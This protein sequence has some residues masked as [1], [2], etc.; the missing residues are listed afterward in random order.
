MRRP[1]SADAARL[2]VVF[3]LAAGLALVELLFGILQHY[4]Q[5]AP[6]AEALDVLAVRPWLLVPLALAAARLS[7]PWR[8]GGY[9]AF[10]LIAGLTESLYVVRMGNPDPWPEMVRGWTAAILLLA[11]VDLALHL[12][13]RTRT[14]WAPIALGAAILLLFAFPPA[15]APYRAIV[16]GGAADRPAQTQPDLL[17]MTALPIVWGEGGAF[18][19]RSQPAL[20]YRALQEEFAIRPIDS[21]DARTL[22]GAG[23]LLLA[24]PRWLAPAELVAVDD[25]V[26]AG[27]RILILTDPQLIWPTGLPLGDIRRPPPVG[28]LK[29]LLDHWGVALD[30]PQAGEVVVVDSGRRLV[31][32]RP[33]RFAATGES[34]RVLGSWRAECRLGA[35]RA[36]LIADADLLRDDLWAA[37]GADGGAMHR[38]L[39]DNPLAVADLLDRLSGID[40]GRVRAPVHWANPTMSP[41]RALILAILPLLAVL[42]VALAASGLLHRGRSA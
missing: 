41:R 37:A 18:D 15:L 24:Q 21:L 39:A 20:A 10:L 16:L 40:R 23:L 17:L 8:I 42:A 28:L 1:T 38:R 19:P 13:R 36:T 5:A 25:W 22:R 31:L 6:R 32:D 14:G 2:C 33:G 7:L 11:A 12:A 4:P 26:R 29:P 30:G 34:C 9:S 35:G 27:G 3:G